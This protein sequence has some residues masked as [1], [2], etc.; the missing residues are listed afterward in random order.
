MKAPKNFYNVVDQKKLGLDQIDKNAAAIAELQDLPILPT[1][2]EG[3]EG[4]VPK[5]NS[6]GGYTLAPDESLPE[7]SAA[8]NGK[9]LTV[10]NGIWSPEL[11]IKDIDSIIAMK[12]T[13]SNGG[14]NSACLPPLTF[15]D[16]IT[17]EVA[18]LVVN[19][20]YTMECSASLVTG[21]LSLTG[22]PDI[23]NANLPA[24]FDIDFINA[25]NIRKYSNIIMTNV[26]AFAYSLAK[27]IKIEVSTDGESY[28]TVYDESTLDWTV[29][30]KEFN[31]YGDPVS[32]LPVP[33]VA[34]AGKVLSVD[35][36]GNWSL[37]KET[38][39]ID[40]ILDSDNSRVVFTESVKDV[41]A[42]VEEHLNAIIYAHNQY[43]ANNGRYFTI[44]DK[45]INTH[46]FISMFNQGSSVNV[47]NFTLD[48]YTTNNYATL[49]DKKINFDT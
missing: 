19:T 44:A 45:Y 32:T 31:I 37:T 27:N 9:V 22:A 17:G 26:V 39:I 40:A 13:I 35:S 6:E 49:T 36:N 29:S 41:Y 28:I 34:D 38:I 10:V 15:N 1:P 4:K 11:L 12:I 3:D 8:D 14:D 43:N 2:G 25:V 24:V 33:T 30:P 42:L 47:L 46:Q 7:V 23:A 21:S 20:D 16:P 48:N 18:N 5:V